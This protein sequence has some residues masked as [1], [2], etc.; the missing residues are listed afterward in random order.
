MQCASKAPA[1]WQS[2]QNQG[3]EGTSFSAGVQHARWQARWQPVLLQSSSGES[4][5]CWPHSMQ[6]TWA[7]PRRLQCLQN[8]SP[9]GASV[10]DGLRQRKWQAQPQNSPSQS[11]ILACSFFLPHSMH[12]LRRQITQ[13]QSPFGASFR[14]GLLQCRWQE[15]PQSFPAQAASSPTSP[16]RPQNM[17]SS[18]SE[19]PPASQTSQSHWPRGTSSSSGRQH[20]RWQALPQAGPSQRRSWSASSCLPQRRHRR[21]PSS[22]RGWS[23]G[24][25]HRF[26]LATVNSHVKGLSRDITKSRTSPTAMA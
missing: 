22:M 2:E 20:F 23:L 8:H 7:L 19:G 14:G 18:T 12:C 21:S 1:H 25:A 5:W 11:S 6:V 4:G 3:P 17:Q 9:S 26:C 16:E 15:R 10:M 13:S 24:L